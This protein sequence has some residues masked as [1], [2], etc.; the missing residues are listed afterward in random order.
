VVKPARVLRVGAGSS[1]VKGVI[2][3][4]LLILTGGEHRY[5]RQTHGLY[6]EGRRP[7]FGE[8]AEADM[9]VAVDVGVD[10]DVVSSEHYLRTVE[11]VLRR[12]LEEQ[13]ED[14]SFVQ[15]S[16]GARHQHR[17]LCEAVVVTEQHGH[18]WRRLPRQRRQL[19]LQPLHS[20]WT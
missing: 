20:W 14:L 12:E 17:P 9:A 2:G 13:R 18:S 11:G 7:V 10:G 19:L 6:G 1:H 16:R 15:C 5:K 3:G 4:S 8:D